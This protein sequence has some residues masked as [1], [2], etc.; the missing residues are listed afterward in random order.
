MLSCCASLGYHVETVEY[1]DWYGAYLR[2]VKIFVCIGHKFSSQKEVGASH[3]AVY[4]ILG[5]HCHVSL[6]CGEEVLLHA[7]LLNG[8]SDS[9]VYPLAYTFRKY[10]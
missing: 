4:G 6:T 10:L 8:Q 1:G 7:S 2:G 9:H 5:P 3:G